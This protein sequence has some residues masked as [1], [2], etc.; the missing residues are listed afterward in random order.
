ML[1]GKLASVIAEP[2][3]EKG[4]QIVKIP[5]GRERKFGLESDYLVGMYYLVYNFDTDKLVETIGFVAEANNQV[6]PA[7][8]LKENDVVFLSYFVMPDSTQVIGS[9]KAISSDEY[10]FTVGSSPPTFEKAA[11][12]PGNDYAFFGFDLRWKP[13][14]SSSVKLQ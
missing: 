10:K 4:P 12:P 13:F 6:N 7:E 9:W 2:V 8:Q 14:A 1:K 11:I 3:T 5:M